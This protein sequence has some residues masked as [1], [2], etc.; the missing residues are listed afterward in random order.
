MKLHLIH[1]RILS[2][3]GEASLGNYDIAFVTSHALD[4]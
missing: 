4:R 3:S 1:L 2:K